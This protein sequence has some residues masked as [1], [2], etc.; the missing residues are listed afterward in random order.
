MWKGKNVNNEIAPRWN[1]PRD[2]KFCSS[3]VISN[4]RPMSVVEIQNKPNTHK[5]TITF[6]EQGICS[7]CRYAE[8]KKKIDWDQRED[9]LA[10]LL[11]RFR[12]SDGRYDCIVPGSGGKDS[13]Y[14]SHILKTKY[15]MNPLTVT[16]APHQFTPIGFHNFQSWIGAGLDNFLV[17][18]NGDLHRKL[19]RLAFLNLMH[20]FQPFIIGQRNVAPRFSVMMDIPLIF[21]GENAVEYGNSLADANDPKM[22]AEFFS[23]ENESEDIYLSGKPVSELMKEWGLPL[24]EFH[25]Y[26]PVSR[27][28]LK[29][30]GTEVHYFSYYYN[31][32]P[33]ENYYYASQHLNFQPNSQ[34]T[35]GSYS[36]YSSIDDKM[37]PFHYYTTFIK[38]GIG[39][40]THDASQE[41]RNGKITRK[42]AVALVQ[43]F[44]SEFPSRYFKDFLEYT[45]LS[46]D[47]FYFTID[48]GRSDHIWK[49]ENGTWVLKHPVI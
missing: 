9:E 30:T 8:T 33:Q 13:G 43:K 10:Q 46:E 27:E 1:L 32:D 42:E 29:K 18:P 38:F 16:W 45:G 31:W 14:V 48:Q 28:K 26:R 4:Q 3:C 5:P 20:P 35:E 2:I 19:T 7:A 49:K 6:D 15:K 22:P 24:S 44:D 21:Y 40:A 17:T 23:S 12:R 47:E 11:N 41:V 37:D 39:R 34:R 25:L 36:K